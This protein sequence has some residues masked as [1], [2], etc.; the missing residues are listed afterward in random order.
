MCGQHSAVLYACLHPHSPFRKL[1]FFE[2]FRFLIFHPFFKGG[3]QLT[4]FAPMCGRPCAEN[5]GGH[6]AAAAA[7]RRAR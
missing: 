4:P 1:V 6:T 5:N 3:G 7:A 2:C